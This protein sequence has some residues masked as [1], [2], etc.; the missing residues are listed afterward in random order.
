MSKTWLVLGLTKVV[1]KSLLQ[2]KSLGSI[3]VSRY[4]KLSAAKQGPFTH[5]VSYITCSFVSSQLC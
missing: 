4:I 5:A 1:K 3:L 2:N